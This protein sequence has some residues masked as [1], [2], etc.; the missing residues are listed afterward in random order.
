MA[1]LPGSTLGMLGGGQLGRMFVTAARTMGYDVI[2]LDPDVHSPAG[3][4]ASEHLARAYDDHEALDYLAQH[5]AVVTTEFENIPADTLAYLARSVAVHPSADALQIAQHRL[6]EKDFFRAQGL[7]TAAFLA[8]EN[9]ADIDRARDFEFPAILKTSTLGYDGKGQVVCARFEDLAEAFQRVGAKACVL[10]QRIDLACEVSVVLGRSLNGQVSCF[11]IAE[12]R[13]A[14]GI[15][16]VTLVPA[17]ISDSLADKA[18]DAATRIAN[19]LDYCGVLAVEFFISTDGRVLVNEMAP[20]P[21]NSGHY[22]NDACVT[23]Q[24]EQQLR[25]V[26]GLAPGS[27]RLHSPVAMLNLLGDIWPPA[28]I[29]DWEEVLQLESAKL[30]LYGKKEARPGR[31]MGHI[32]CLGA[33]R[34]ETLTLLEKVRRILA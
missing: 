33:S 2:V 31:K 18:L 1:I 6:R 11:P 21:H 34:E 16:D 22:T 10:E 8:I 9:E 19:G 17:A 30:H 32:N 24:F 7:D 26:C 23:S 27:C 20:R 13:H 29:P 14:N 3:G 25:M 12:N 28:G 4:L 15:L 5:C